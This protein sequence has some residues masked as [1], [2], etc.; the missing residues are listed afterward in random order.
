M[1]L[2]DE[3]KLKPCPFCGGE[4]SMFYSGSSDWEITCKTCPVET[5]FWIDAGK[6]GY[7]EGESKEARRR[8]NAR[9]VIAAHDKGREGDWLDK[10]RSELWRVQEKEFPESTPLPAGAFIPMSR[11]QLEVITTIPSGIWYKTAQGHIG[12][13]YGTG[14][15]EYMSGFAAAPSPTQQDAE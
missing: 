7:G 12:Y 5:R 8:W 14:G 6:H 15:S 10:R 1:T 11:A 4:V 3:Q 9:A 13:R 2:T